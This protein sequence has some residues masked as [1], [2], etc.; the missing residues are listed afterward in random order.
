MS[1]YLENPWI[2]A[3]ALFIYFLRRVLFTSW[4]NV[5]FKLNR[6][7]FFF[8]KCFPFFIYSILSYFSNLSLISSSR[9]E[10]N[11][12]HGSSHKDFP[13]DKLDDCVLLF[14]R[15][16]FYA[17][18]ADT[19]YYDLEM[20][21]RGLPYLSI[22]FEDVRKWGGSRHGAHALPRA[23]GE[24][25]FLWPSN[26]LIFSIFILWIVGLLDMDHNTCSL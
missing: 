12:L 15:K 18:G 26:I 10:R 11:T 2:S 7:F 13:Y 3:F 8:F 6:V 9:R 1:W 16:L 14:R 5:G 22:G 24:C 25:Y 19:V 23:C 20:D 21:Y 17:S 4:K